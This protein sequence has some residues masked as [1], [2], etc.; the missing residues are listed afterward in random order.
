MWVCVLVCVSVILSCP[1]SILIG[2]QWKATLTMIEQTI[3]AV[4][5]DTFSSY[6]LSHSVL[7]AEVPTFLLQY[8]LLS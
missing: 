6:S 4:Q 3:T 2:P 1:L 7:K 5:R 8:F